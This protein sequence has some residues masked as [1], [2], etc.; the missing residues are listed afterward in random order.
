MS[1]PCAKVDVPLPQL[2]TVTAAA[3]GSGSRPPGHLKSLL[4]PDRAKSQAALTHPGAST[5]G[6]FQKQTRQRFKIN[7]EPV[8]SPWAALVTTCCWAGQG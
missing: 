8:I 5:D 3:S 2:L 1:S 4:C 7:E 6:A